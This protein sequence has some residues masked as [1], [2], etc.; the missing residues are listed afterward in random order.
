MCTTTMFVAERVL[1]PTVKKEEAAYCSE[2]QDN[3]HVKLEFFILVF[4]GESMGVNNEKMINTNIRH[5]FS[6][7][8]K[9]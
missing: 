2:H 9:G 7:V 4:V 1:S 8:L 6:A 3:C 5:S